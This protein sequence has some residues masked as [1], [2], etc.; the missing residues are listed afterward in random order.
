M[1]RPKAPRGHQPICIAVLGVRKGA[2]NMNRLITSGILLVLAVKCIPASMDALGTI[3]V[4]IVSGNLDSVTFAIIP[5][6]F[7]AILWA[8]VTLGILF[9]R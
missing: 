8:L 1:Y 7:P 9:R 4:A 5:E 3:L 6:A 2:R